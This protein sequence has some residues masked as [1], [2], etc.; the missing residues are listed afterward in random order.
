MT[1]V[2]ETTYCTCAEVRKVSNWE[3]PPPVGIQTV[4]HIC[5]TRCRHGICISSSFAPSGHLRTNSSGGGG[6]RIWVLIS[7]NILCILLRPVETTCGAR[8]MITLRIRNKARR[9]RW[10]TSL[11]RACLVREAPATQHPTRGVMTTRPVQIIARPCTF[12]YILLLYQTYVWVCVCT[13]THTYVSWYYD[14]MIVLLCTTKKKNKISEKKQQKWRHYCRVG[15]GGGGQV[16]WP[17]CRV[18]AIVSQS[19]R[20]PARPPTDRRRHP[21]PRPLLHRRCTRDRRR[22]RRHTHYIYITLNNVK[23]LRSCTTGNVAP[24]QRN[25]RWYS[26]RTHVVSTTVDTDRERKWWT[27]KRT[28]LDRYRKK[29][30]S[31]GYIRLLFFFAF[32]PKKSFFSTD[33]DTHN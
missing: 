30:D 19:D 2:L 18:K 20:P 28:K 5:N 27:R 6:G 12:I 3:I 1:A 31:D 33:S 32:E 4:P 16:Q 13:R 17:C 25:T 9:P 14:N 22:R 8:V 29:I 10:R 26:S 21:P 24:P 23:K 15:C 11:T 7:P